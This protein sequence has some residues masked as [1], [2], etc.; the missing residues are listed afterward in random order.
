LPR[1]T[2]YGQPRAG[3]L[4]F[5]S[6][7]SS[8]LSFFLSDDSR[9]VEIVLSFLSRFLILPT[10]AAAEAACRADV[11]FLHLVCKMVS[12]RSRSVRTTLTHSNFFRIDR[13]FGTSFAFRSHR[14]LFPLLAFAAPMIHSFPHLQIPPTIRQFFPPFSF[15]GCLLLAFCPAAL[16][17]QNFSFHLRLVLEIVFFFLWLSR[18]KNCSLRH[19]HHKNSSLF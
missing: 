10:P 2:R 9:L 3:F 15:V 17:A 11:P 14:Y 7:D 18:D 5:P 13:K 8:S 12:P 6:F 16:T 1:G 19:Q 4:S